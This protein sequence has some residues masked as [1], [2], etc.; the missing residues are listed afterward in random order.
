MSPYESTRVRFGKMR[1]VSTLDVDDEFV[2]VDTESSRSKTRELPE[3][4]PLTQTDTDVWLESCS[5]S[6][7]IDLYVNRNCK[8]WVS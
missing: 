4:L 7:A 8:R 5:S 1:A 6:K 2:L 3:P